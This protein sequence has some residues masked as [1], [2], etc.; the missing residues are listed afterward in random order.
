MIAYKLVNLVGLAFSWPRGYKLV[1]IRKIWC[2]KWDWWHSGRKDTLVKPTP[3]I[4]PVFGLDCA[5]HAKCDGTKSDSVLAGPVR[6]ISAFMICT[7]G[8]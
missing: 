1:T 7:Y 8:P 3:T 5:F 4:I 2:A 6:V